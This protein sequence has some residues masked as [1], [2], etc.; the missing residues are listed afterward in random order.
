MRVP[1]T[2]TPLHDAMPVAIA[3]CVG[4]TMASL[5]RTRSNG[6]DLRSAVS[7]E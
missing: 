4:A 3:G 7:A 5:V 1:V 2:G 6:F